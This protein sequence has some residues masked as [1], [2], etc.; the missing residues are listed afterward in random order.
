MS[1]RM[2]GAAVAAGLFLLAGQVVAQD[3]AASK[4]DEEMIFDFEGPAAATSW[5]NID[6][7]VG[8]AKQYAEA[9]KAV[10]GT[11]KPAPWKPTTRPAEPQVKAEIVTDGATSGKQALKITFDGGEWPTIGTTA[12]P[13]VRW[14]A[15]KTI[16]ADVTVPRPCVIGFCMMQE[17][18][19]RGDGYNEG[20]SRWDATAFLHA[21]KNE[22]VLPLVERGSPRIDKS[23]GNVVSFEIYMYEPRKGESIL[24]DNIRASRT[25]PAEPPKVEFSVL[26]TDMTFKANYSGDA[27]A[28]LNKKLKDKWVKAEPKTLDQVEADFRKQFEDIKA[29]NPK[30]VLAIFRDGEAGFDAKDPQKVFAGWKDAYVNGH[31][32]DGCVWGRAAKHGKETYSEQFMRHRGRLNQV[33]LSAIP[34]GS[35]I[36]A[37]QFIQINAGMKAD[38]VAE[39]PTMWVAEVCNR[40]WDEA[41][42][43]AYQYAKEKFWKNISGWSWDGDD[44]D[45]LP[46]FVAYGPTQGRVNVWDFTQAVK[47]W[48]DG[49]HPNRGFFW[50]GDTTYL[51]PGNCPTRETEKVKDRP[52]VM[53]IYEPK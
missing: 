11:T 26:G 20:V 21:G 47:Y 48:T 30:A 27:L 31:G 41:E 42:V 1:N 34:T 3:S 51:W 6:V 18:S 33:D 52:A 39:T 50:H 7:N 12:V 9:L 19:L 29:K 22:V 40:E 13:E 38:Q 32:P 10:E 2:I 23:R 16:V 53:V 43:N 35:T 24:V 17:K 25:K 14:A 28:E 5:V 44:P 46:L 45:F 4:P 36:L 37:A 15:Y 8:V 49:K